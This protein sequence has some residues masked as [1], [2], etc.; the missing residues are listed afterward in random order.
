[1]D[2]VY[3][4]NNNFNVW[5]VVMYSETLISASDREGLRCRYYLIDGAGSYGISV[6]NI[7]TGEKLCIPEISVSRTET[8]SL[9]SLLC[10]GGVTTLTFPEV[11][12]DWLCT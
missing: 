9:V 5:E 1:M 6:L 8:L 12:E 2:A 4:K 11:V 3:N 7:E 10:R